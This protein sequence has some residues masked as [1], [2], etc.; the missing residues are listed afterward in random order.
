MEPAD[1]YYCETPLHP[2]KIGVWAAIS[3]RQIIGLFE[4]N[5]INNW[6]NQCNLLQSN[7]TATRYHQKILT[8]FIPQFHNDEI[9]IGYFQ[10]NFFNNWIISRNTENIWPLR[11]CDITPAWIEVESSC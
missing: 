7:L 8:D 3:Q 6:F 11:S 1:Q 9:E 5:H 10:Q 2:Q 4:G